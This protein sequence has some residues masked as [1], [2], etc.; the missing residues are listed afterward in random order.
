M[1]HYSQ[2]RVAIAAAIAASRVASAIVRGSLRVSGRSRES[3][4]RGQ[5]ASTGTRAL[6]TA[7]TRCAYNRSPF[8]EDEN[9]REAVAMKR[10][11]GA[12]DEEGEK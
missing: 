6:A 11:S 5:H 8:S 4:S 12:G 7:R 3:A 10:S 2:V 1:Y 9:E